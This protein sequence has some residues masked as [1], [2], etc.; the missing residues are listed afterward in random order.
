MILCYLRGRTHDQAADELRCPVGTVR[1]RL[2][3][4]RDLL[5]K[6]LDAPGVRPSAM[7]AVL[8]MGPSLAVQAPRRGRPAVAGLRGGEGGFSRFGSAQ[9][10]Q[11]GAT[12][13]SA[14]ALA[15]G[16]L[17]TM[18]I[19]QLKWI[20]LAVLASSLSAGGVVAVSYA[21]ARQPAPAAS[22]EFRLVHLR[23]AGS[24]RNPV[25]VT[26]LPGC[27]RNSRSRRMTIPARR[28]HSPR[29]SASYATSLRT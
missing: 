3:R 5:R 17:T 14:L 22:F 6:R 28:I 29:S 9:T 2:A 21:S 19:A 16:V 4:G 26:R 25:R 24:S 15:Q 12:A 27:P 18:R 13:T 11:T 10:I 1:S 23:L 20:G 8:G 7:V